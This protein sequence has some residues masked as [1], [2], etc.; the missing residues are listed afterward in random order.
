MI[1]KA[2]T[3]IMGLVIIVILIIIGMVFVIRF[4]IFDEPIDYKKQFIQTELASNMLNTL[5]KTTSGC[6]G[7]SM[8]ELIR[9]CNQDK[10]IICNGKDSCSY[11]IEETEQIFMDT[12]EKWNVDYEFKVFNEEDKP[13]ITL[14]KK[15]VGDKRSKLF[16]IPTESEILFVKMDVC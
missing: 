13:I 4:F 9:D 15:C 11:F 2:Q 12:L 7:L 6:G 8:T 1:K 10:S 14:G 3:E 5:L 16:S